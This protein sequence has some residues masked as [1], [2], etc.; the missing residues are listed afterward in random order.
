MEKGQRA[1]PRRRLGPEHVACLREE[2]L[3]S[4]GGAPFERVIVGRIGNHLGAFISGERR[5]HWIIG[6][7]SSRMKAGEDGRG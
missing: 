4:S 7:S 6:L 1:G 3:H 5:E 2:G